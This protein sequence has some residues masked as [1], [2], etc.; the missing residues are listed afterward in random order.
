MHGQVNVAVTSMNNVKVTS[1]CA[2]KTAQSS[3][4]YVHEMW[5]LHIGGILIL[6]SI[7]FTSSIDQKQLEVVVLTPRAGHSSSPPF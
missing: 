6:L 2:N 4:I 5:Q 1:T 3:R 7:Q